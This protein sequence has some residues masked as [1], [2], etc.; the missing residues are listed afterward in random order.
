MPGMALEFLNSIGGSAYLLRR[1]IEPDIEYRLL[2]EA[3]DAIL[4]V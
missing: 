2:Y 4:S 3:Q 1:I